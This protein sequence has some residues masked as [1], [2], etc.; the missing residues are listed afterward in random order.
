MSIGLTQLI[1]TLR[2]LPVSLQINPKRGKYSLPASNDGY[3]INPKKFKNEIKDLDVN[4]KD[5][6]YLLIMMLKG[7]PEFIEKLIRTDNSRFVNMKA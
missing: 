5:I 3:I 6:K 4:F 2:E 1:P 7:N